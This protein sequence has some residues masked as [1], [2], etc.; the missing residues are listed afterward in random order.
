MLGQEIERMLK[1][2]KSGHYQFVKWWRKE[3]DFLDYDLIDSFMA[4]LSDSEEIDGIELLTMDDMW[5]EVQ[6]V[7]GERVKK[8]HE[9]SGDKVEWAHEGKTGLHKEVCVY[10]PETLM[11]IFDVETRGNPVDS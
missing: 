1:A 10:C 3:N 8:V 2:D 7:A 4:Q 11:S 9:K 5:R 6:R